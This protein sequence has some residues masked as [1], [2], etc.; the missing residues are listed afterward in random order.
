MDIVR[1]NTENNNNIKIPDDLVNNF[2]FDRNLRQFYNVPDYDKETIRYLSGN[3]STVKDK[4]F[5][6]QDEKFIQ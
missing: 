3:P 2:I 4:I 1:K 6:K 5:V